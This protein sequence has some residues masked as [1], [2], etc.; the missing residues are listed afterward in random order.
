VRTSK[1][2][3]LSGASSRSRPNHPVNGDARASI[4]PCP[5]SAARA[6]YWER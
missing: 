3:K 2:M 4:A 1:Q 5:T 6:R